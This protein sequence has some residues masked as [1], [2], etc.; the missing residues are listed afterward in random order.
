MQ[1]PFL[2]E[3]LA[4]NGKPI[5]ELRA[6]YQKL[7]GEGKSIPGNKKFLIKRIAYK[8][9]E[10]KYGGL[11]QEAKEKVGTL[12][13]KFDPINNKTATPAPK[14]GHK[15]TKDRRLPIPGTVI[16]KVYKGK[17]LEVKVLEN[18]FEYKGTVYRS[19]SGIAKDI[20]GNGWNG[21]LFFGL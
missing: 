17:K 10:F 21:F 5:K 8:L 1:N 16:T 3:I 13:K 11:S 18:G 2:N 19:L 7:F 6:K 9:Q 4:L 15:P 20:T 14:S 12:I